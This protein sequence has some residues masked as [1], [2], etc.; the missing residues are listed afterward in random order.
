MLQTEKF[1]LAVWLLL[2]FCI[3]TMYKS[4]L[5]A[6]ITI[7]KPTIP[8]NTLE[9]LVENTDYIPQMHIGTHLTKIT[10]VK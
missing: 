2:G 4:N 8:F 9:E 10:K 1:F 6:M 5:L 3:A 7:R